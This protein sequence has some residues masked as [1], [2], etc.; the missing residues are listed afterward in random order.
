MYHPNNPNFCLPENH[1]SCVF[2]RVFDALKQGG[3]FNMDLSLFLKVLISQ[4][5]MMKAI[6]GFLR[7]V[8]ESGAKGYEVCLGVTI[9]ELCLVAMLLKR[10]GKQLFY[11]GGGGHFALYLDGDL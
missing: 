10:H 11:I 5:R 8:L 4:P 6:Y 2:S 3:E 7:S 9:F 1:R